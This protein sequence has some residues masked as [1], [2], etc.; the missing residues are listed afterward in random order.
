MLHTSINIKRFLNKSRC[1]IRINCSNRRFIRFSQDRLAIF[2]AHTL[3][4]PRVL[5]IGYPMKK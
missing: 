2:S 5:K 3:S 4:V 1:M